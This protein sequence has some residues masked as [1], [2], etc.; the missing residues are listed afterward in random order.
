M[1]MKFDM[2]T[3]TLSTLTNQTSTNSEDLGSLVR[4]LVADV[5]PLEG[6]F[7]GSGRARFDDFKSRTDEIA[8]ELNNS[9]GAIL[10]G[11][12]GMD[13]AFQT[14]DQETADNAA[15][16]GSSA[17]FAAADFKSRR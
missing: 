2:G 3:Q 17:D 5:A 15:Q 8:N 14:G 12:S 10:E 4:K 11:Q 6:K 7:N 16:A 1:S 9:L 13:L